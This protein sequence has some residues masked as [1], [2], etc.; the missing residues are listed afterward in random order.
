MNT[1]QIKTYIEENNIQKIK[2][3]F[4]DIDGVLRGKV[5]HP[6]KFLEGLQSGY[7]FCDVVFGWD[8]NDVC[9]D[10]VKAYR[11]AYRLP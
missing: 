9:Y 4:A 5:I 1:E 2:F 11:L 8:S 10:N 3:A 7:G 6:K